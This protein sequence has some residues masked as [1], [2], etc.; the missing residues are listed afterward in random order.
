[1]PTFVAPKALAD[2]S[3]PA[4]IKPIAKTVFVIAPS[5]PDRGP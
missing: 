1:M 2:A 3:T 4:I 5:T